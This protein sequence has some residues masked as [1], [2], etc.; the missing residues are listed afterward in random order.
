MKSNSR[1]H[2]SASV[3]LCMA[4]VSFVSPAQAEEQSPTGLYLGLGLGIAVEQFN[5]SVDFDPGL[6][7]TLDVGYR[8]HPH[9]AVEGTCEYLKGIHGDDSPATDIDALS[10][11]G[12]I[13]GYL[14]K[15]RVQPY[16]VFGLGVT[17]MQIEKGPSSKKKVGITV[18][19]GGGVDYYLIPGVSLGIKVVYVEATGKIQHKDHISIGLGAQYR[20]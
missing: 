9:F 1:L 20:F 3:I 18:R 14:L 16:V 12:N 10:F 2:L 13:K 7:F 5:S 11:S 15:T 6:G 4:V 19:V 8:F 17:R